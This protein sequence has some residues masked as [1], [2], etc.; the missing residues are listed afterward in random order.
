MSYGWIEGLGTLREPEKQSDGT[1]VHDF[2]SETHRHELETTICGIEPD[3][4]YLRSG[5]GRLIGKD[6]D[7]P[8]TVDASIRGARGRCDVTLGLGQLHPML[9]VRSSVASTDRNRGGGVNSLYFPLYDILMPRLHHPSEV[10]RQAA[11]ANVRSLR[12]RPTE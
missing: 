9:V 11:A 5:T 10:R 7:K 4:F 2:P 8:N 3:N 1:F 6:R 12:S